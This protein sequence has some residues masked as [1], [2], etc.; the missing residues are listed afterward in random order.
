MIAFDPDR[1]RHVDQLI[2]A[3]AAAGVAV[4]RAAK[5]AAATDEIAAA[6][7]HDTGDVGSGC[8][9]RTPPCCARSPTR[10]SSMTR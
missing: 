1:H 8:G 10:R 4:D 2:R 9:T 6:A 7:H 5:L 3:A